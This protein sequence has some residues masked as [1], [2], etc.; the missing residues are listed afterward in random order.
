MQVYS[1]DTGLFKLDGGAMFGV[2]PKVI[3]NKL[4]PADENNLCTWSMRCM[5]V[6]DGERRI[7]IDTGM[8]TKQSEK[9]F[10]HY[11][12][13]GEGELLKSLNQLG[14]SAN[15]ITDVILTHLHFDHCGGAVNL[16]NEKLIPA[17]PQAIYWSTA[18][19]WE[20]AINPN[21]REKAS[22][23]K[24]NFVPLQE[25]GQLKFIEEKEG[26]L[27]RFSNNIDILFAHGHTQSMM[28]PLVKYKEKTICYMADLIPSSMHVPLPF[29]MG[30][31]MFPMTTLIEKEIF[32]KKA[33]QENY[34]LFFEHDPSGECCTVELTE[35]GYKRKE[36]FNLDAL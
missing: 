17:F 8:G 11:Y 13:H 15:D 12:L 31:D 3:W 1:V 22:F 29:V 30:Y 26:E 28:L 10:S 35:R 4:N 36:V 21:N 27:T 14:F 7:L 34:I 9:F 23:L 20:W 18:K 6:V 5:L 32:L 2:V 24:E 19:H 16:V 25:H 33:C